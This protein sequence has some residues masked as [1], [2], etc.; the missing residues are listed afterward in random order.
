M[1][2]GNPICNVSWNQLKVLHLPINYQVYLWDIP[3]MFLGFLDKI[4]AHPNHYKPYDS[5]KG[6]VAMPSLDL[7][8]G[9]FR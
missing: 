6:R 3:C 7:S 4:I 9:S 2:Y 1:I 8:P 5:D